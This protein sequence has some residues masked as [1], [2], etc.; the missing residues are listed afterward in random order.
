MGTSSRKMDKSLWQTLGTFDF[1]HLHQWLQARLS[2]D[3]CYTA[4]QIGIVPRCWFCWTSWGLN[5]LR[6]NSVYLR[7]SNVR[8][9]KLDV[10][11]TNLSLTQSCW[12][13]SYFFRCRCSMD[14]IPALDLCNL[15][16]EVLH[17]SWIQSTARCEQPISHV[18]FSRHLH[19]LIFDVTSTLGQVW[20]AAR[21]FHS[22]HLHAF[23]MWLF[24]FSTILPFH[25]LLSTFTPIVSCIL[26]VV[27]FFLLD[28]EDKYPAHSRKSGPWHPCRARPSH[29]KW[30]QRLPH[31]GD[32]W[33]VHPGIL[34]ERVPEFVWLWA[35]WLHHWHSALFT[36]HS[37][38]IRCSEPQAVVVCRS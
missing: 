10:Q 37:G 8:S 13:W 1:M 33:T 32:H 36:T 30:A 26:L 12:I 35:R 14:G 5:R 11:E 20:R 9:H 22:I 38:A 6:V 2:C 25:F 3:K 7:E 21:T 31:L 23:M 4:L 29:R 27:S 16:V 18:T 28:V 34:R 19:A 24:W 17:S 15:V